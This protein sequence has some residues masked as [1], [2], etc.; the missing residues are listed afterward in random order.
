[1]DLYLKSRLSC[2]LWLNSPYS[3]GECQG[4]ISYLAPSPPMLKVW[5][6]SVPSLAVFREYIMRLW[7]YHLLQKLGTTNQKM[8]AKQRREIPCS[9]RAIGMKW[10]LRYPTK[11]NAT[12]VVVYRAA[13]EHSRE[14]RRP[15]LALLHFP[16]RSVRAVLHRPSCSLSQENDDVEAANRESKTN[17][18][19]TKWGTR[20]S[21]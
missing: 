20:D 5:P 7:R 11:S 10:R 12:D 4:E 6:L 3:R 18:W 17:S 21:R 1:L 15:G 14:D 9:A 2:V 19:T 13:R 8:Q 16:S